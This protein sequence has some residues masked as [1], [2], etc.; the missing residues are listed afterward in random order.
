MGSP[1]S[2]L[3]AEIT[4]QFVENN[5]L[6]HTPL[7]PFFYKRYVDDVFI[8]WP[9]SQSKL[10][11][12]L[13]DF[14]SQLPSINFTIEHEKNYSLNFLDLS[15]HRTANNDFIW[16]D[17]FIKPSNLHIPIPF[18]SFGPI[19]YKKSFF[20]SHISRALA[21]TSFNFLENTQLNKI[22]Q[23]AKSAGYSNRFINLLIKKQISNHPFPKK[24]PE[25]PQFSTAI[26]FTPVFNHI[27]RFIKRKFKITV[28]Y[29]QPTNIKQLILSDRDL[30]PPS[31]G[32][33][34]IPI[35][36]PS[37]RVFYI[38]QTFRTIKSRISEHKSSLSSNYGNTALKAFLLKS[39][40]AIPLWNEVKTL[41]S[42][43]NYEEL[44]WR[45]TIEIETEKDNVNTKNG[46]QLAQ[47][48]QPILAEFPSKTD[49]SLLTQIQ[50]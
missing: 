21:Y 11:S 13:N 31:G 35:Q 2:P 25:P 15:I 39:P 8:I 46:R 12:L 28:P 24:D 48:W 47:V 42:P 40:S 41:S 50:L 26:P 17:I 10:I 22:K 49:R 33:Y 5:V 38:G 18:H 1:I 43:V 30:V 6:L 14:C 45:E 37:K 36:L 29:S 3:C 7:P 27:T 34:S 16:F 19:N 32:V 44:M 9:F 4:L 23:I 20:R